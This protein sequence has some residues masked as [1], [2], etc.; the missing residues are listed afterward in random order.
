MTDALN[1]SPTTLAKLGS[2]VVHIEE[3]LSPEGHHFDRGAI[4]SLLRDPEV[5][6]WLAGMR[7]LALLP[8]KRS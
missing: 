1:P 2:I 6:Q 7:L 8:E 5:V 3:Y 4:E